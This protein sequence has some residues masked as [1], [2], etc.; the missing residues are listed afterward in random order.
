V[1]EKFLTYFSIHISKQLTGF[2][3]NSFNGEKK[4]YFEH[5]VEKRSTNLN[6]NS[7]LSYVLRFCFRE[8]KVDERPR[9]LALCVSA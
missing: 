3:A 2:W 9:I 8:L 7:L 1:T 6:A 5:R 4:E